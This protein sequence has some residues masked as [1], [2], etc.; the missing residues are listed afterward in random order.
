MEPSQ[1]L[2]KAREEL[3]Q[4]NIETLRKMAATGIDGRYSVTDAKAELG[5]AYSNRE[6]LI[7]IILDNLNIGYLSED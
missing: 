7:E 3:R 4:E 1:R 6:A 2:D 5:M